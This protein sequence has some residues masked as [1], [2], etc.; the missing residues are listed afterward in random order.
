VIRCDVASGR[1]RTLFWRDGLSSLN[2]TA[3]KISQLDVLAPGRLLFSQRRR[4]QNLREIVLAAGKTVSASHLLATGSS[5]DR[6]PVYSPDGEQILFSSNRGGNLD[7][8]MIARKKRVLRR[9]TD[10]PADDWDP[11]FMPDGR[12]ILWS[13][14]RGSGHLEVWLAN[15]DGSDARQVSSD[16]VSAQNP[17]PTADGRWIVYWSGNPKKLGVWKVHPDGTGA[18]L[19]ARAVNPALS[20]VSSD[21]RYAFWIDMDRLNL[22]N[23]LHV[24]EVDSGR[25]VPFTIKVPYTLGAP[26]ITWG[27][28]RWSPDG[29]A[30]YF[31]G[32]NEQGLS[33]IY[34]Q[35]FDPDHD[36]TATRRPVAGFSPEFVTESFGVS[37]DGTH[38]TLSMGQESEALLVAEGVP[39]ALPQ[40]R[41]S[42]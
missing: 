10:D 13:S 35:R 18:T 26:A 14:N 42:P 38:L 39:G 9:M 17:E 37:P 12:H 8:W 34:E 27:R 30:I 40:L 28:A 11:A 24:V 23:T 36:T 25:V 3:S 21:G 15:T 33:G 41:R 29:R 20:G 4:S 32:E 31:V 2:S 5:I 19:L 1:R 16:G 22:T 7:L 6:Q